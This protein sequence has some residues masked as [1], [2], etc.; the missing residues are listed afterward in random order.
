MPAGSKLFSLREDPHSTKA[1]KI[2]FDSVA[3][4][5]TAFI[6]LNGDTLAVMRQQFICAITDTRYRIPI[7]SSHKSKEKM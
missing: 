3:S 5:K 7:S 6:S 1:D 4:L 2:C